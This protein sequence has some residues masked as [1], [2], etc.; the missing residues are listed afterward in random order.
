MVRVVTR[1]GVGELSDPLVRR[2]RPS[3]PG[4][5]PMYLEVTPQVTRYYHLFFQWDPYIESLGSW[6]VVARPVLQNVCCC[7]QTLLIFP[8]ALQP[9]Q[10][11]TSINT[12]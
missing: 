6:E 7:R 10:M 4:S 2:T 8:G 3:A 11:A 1:G 12:R 9:N 5:P